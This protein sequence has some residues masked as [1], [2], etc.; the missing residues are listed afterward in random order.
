MDKYNQAILALLR[1]NARLSWREIGEQVFLTGQAVGARVQ[2]MQEQG[3]IQGYTLRENA[4]HCHF[5][6]IFMHSNDFAGFE[7][8]IAQ[9]SH[10]QA[11]YKVSG[12][13]CYQLIAHC[14]SSIDLEELTDLIQPYATYKIASALTRV[15]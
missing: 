10:V 3:I 6:S 2:Q 15:K 13:A 14:P 7:R 11:A 9:S 1:Q 5:I 4:Q 12:E 8:A